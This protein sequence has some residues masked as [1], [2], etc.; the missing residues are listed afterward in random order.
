MQWGGDDWAADFPGSTNNISSS[1]RNNYTKVKTTTTTTTMSDENQVKIKIKISKKQLEEILGRSNNSIP[2]N[3]H[4]HNEHDVVAHLI[5]YATQYYDQLF[6]YH[7]HH[8]RPWS[9]ALPTINEL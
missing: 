1:S 6:D 3:N 8:Q 2:I 4:G 7:D 9:P 5:N